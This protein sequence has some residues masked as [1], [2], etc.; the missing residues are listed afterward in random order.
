MI[1]L[2][3]AFKVCDID[4]EYLWFRATDNPR[5]SYLIDE[6]K[7]RKLFDM[8]KVKVHKIC[9]AFS[10]DDFYGWDFLVSGIT[11]EELRYLFFE[12]R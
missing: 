2:S 10:Y 1:T 3:E 12:K 9:L 4:G 8:K 11:S 6:H 5:E 7:V